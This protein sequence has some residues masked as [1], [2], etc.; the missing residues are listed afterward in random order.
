[1]NA[2]LNPE[3][4]PPPSVPLVQLKGFIAKIEDLRIC[5]ESPSSLSRKICLQMVFGLNCQR[6]TRAK[7]RGGLLNA[8]RSIA[9]GRKI[10]DHAVKVKCN[11][12]L[13]S[14]M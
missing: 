3:S 10:L 14:V 13:S 12:S 6:A 9:A 4:T 2:I 11:V 8:A 7:T 1:M 5:G